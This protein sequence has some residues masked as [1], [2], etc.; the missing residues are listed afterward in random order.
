MIEV[1]QITKKFKNTIALHDFSC[2]FGNGI[3]A[4]LG[5][6][7]AGKSTLM[8]ILMTIEK[9]TSGSIVCDSKNILDMKEEYLSETSYMPQMQ[10]LYED[11]TGFEFLMYVGL[12][13]SVKKDVII[14]RINKYSY[15]LDLNNKLNEKIKSYSGGMKQRLLFIAS[16]LNKPKI[17]FLDEPTAGLDPNQRI[18]LKNIISELSLDTAIVIATH[19]V[20]DVEDISN[21]LVFINKGEKILQCD[22]DHFKDDFDA[23]VYEAVL[24][25]NDVEK[26]KKKCLIS[27]SRK[28]DN[29]LMVRFIS[30]NEI[31]GLKPLTPTLDDYY[32]WRM[33][34]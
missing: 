11:F 29:K 2:Q 9:P 21:S 26:L 25:A 30:N 17:L 27:N 8:S 3:T 22:T 33:G 13:K 16:I 15:N 19:I 6:N 12:L 5:P 32:L 10:S 34:T 14:E 4:I 1:K 23:Y 7:G 18:K 24:N 31:L 20:Q 28:L